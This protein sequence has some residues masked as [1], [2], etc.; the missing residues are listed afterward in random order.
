MYILRVLFFF[1]RE[2]NRGSIRRGVG[3]NSSL[4]KVAIQLFSDVSKVYR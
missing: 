1:S 4:D 3:P 2:Q